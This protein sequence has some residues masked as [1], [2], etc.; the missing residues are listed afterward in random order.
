MT[1]AMQAIDLKNLDKYG[2]KTYRFDEIAKNISERV[3]PN[4]TDLKVY[5][6]LEHIDPE[7][8]HI[9]RTGT[10]DDVNGQKLR[11][12][13]DDVIFGRRRAYQRKA[14]ITTVDG[15]CSAHALVLRA[16]PDVI[17]PKLFPFFLHSDLFMHRAV[18][19]SVGSLSPTINW[20]TLKHQKFMLP[21]KHQQAKLAELLWA[22]DE[23]IERYWK[24]KE[25]LEVKK[26][27]ISYDCYYSKD[28]KKVALGALCLKI[29]D[30]SH[31]SPQNIYDKNN[32]ERYRYVTSKNIRKNGLEFNEDEYV[33]KSFH[34]SI[35][36]R[37]DTIKGDVL[38]TKDGANTGTA[39]LNTLDEEVSLLSSVCLLRANTKL[40][41][42]E[43]ICQYINSDIGNLN[44]TNQMTG[45]AITRLTLTTINNI[46]I[47]VPDLQRQ[48][49]ITRELVRFDSCIKAVA[50]SLV[51]SRNLQK[52][53]IN[54]IF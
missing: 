33:D 37:C 26:R 10:P 32:G 21:P 18:D 14:S 2:W 35:Y 6:G 53:L 25:S 40:T 24:V 44:L 8:I 13:P 52:S 23:I 11:C 15:F 20:G 9:K 49:E 50:D 39:T 22:M 17:E 4:N 12:Y 30:G 36:N 45:T 38:L 46:K 54:Q 48:Q 29:Q 43:Y 7:S 16:N 27:R 1:E 5:I 34:D 51:S 19:I 3:D 31:L 42:N 28:V 47:P 41:S